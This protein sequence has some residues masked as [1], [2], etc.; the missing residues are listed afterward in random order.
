VAQT[1]PLF[2]E[3]YLNAIAP[4]YYLGM[5]CALVPARGLSPRWRNLP[6]AIG[7]AF[8]GVSAGYS[9]HNHYCDPRYQKSPDWR[10]LTDYLEAEVQPEDVIILNYPDPT[11]SYYYHG[12]APSQ[13]LPRGQLTDQEKVETAEALRDIADRYDRVWLYPVRD[14]GW[15]S[16]GYVEKWLDRH[17]L[18]VDERDIHGFRW[19]I[20]TPTVVSPREVQYPVRVG[21]GDAIVLWGYDCDQCQTADSGPLSVQ[22]GAT[23]HLTL[24]WEAT[25]R[26]Q[27]PYS[28][29]IHLVDASGRVIAQRDSAPRGGDF[30]TQEWMPGDVIVDPY[31]IAIPS[32]TQP[33][34]HTVIVGMYDPVTG[35]RLPV[36]DGQ[37]SYLGDH[38][39]VARLAVEQWDTG[40]HP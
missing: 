38:V 24:Y 33:G 6:L 31:S 40:Q 26:V 19:L 35:E 11:F 17:A 30:P 9:L 28:V 36:T 15:D 4:A 23:L 13:I 1:R 10:G 14:A 8:L 16:E 3:R 37:G 21:L 20:Y 25:D 39:T 7:V 18:L 22:P 12:P 2:R 32:D 5:S 34:A 29:F 27:T